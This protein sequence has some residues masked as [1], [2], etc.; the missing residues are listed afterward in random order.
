MSVNADYLSFILTDPR[1]PSDPHTV[2]YVKNESFSQSLLTSGG[3]SVLPRAIDGVRAVGAATRASP[4]PGVDYQYDFYYVRNRHSLAFDEMGGAPIDLDPFIDYGSIMYGEKLEG[5]KPPDL[6]RS[7]FGGVPYTFGGWYVEAGGFTRLDFNALPSARMPNDDLLLFA[8][9]DAPSYTARFFDAVGGAGLGIDQSVAREGKAE[10]PAGYVRGVTY[11]AGKG[12]FNGWLYYSP[13]GVLTQYNFDLPVTRDMALYANWRTNGFAVS[14][15]S[16]AG[17]GAVPVDNLRYGLFTTARALGGEGLIPPAGHV[18]Y[19]WRIEG[20]LTGTSYL[21]GSLFTIVNDMTL[22][23]QYYPQR[24]TPPADGYDPGPDLPPAAPTPAP[25]PTEESP[26]IE[27]DPQAPEE[28][29]I[30]DVETPLAEDPEERGEGNGTPTPPS[31][32][33][34]QN[35]ERPDREEPPP[36]RDE[37]Q[38]VRDEPQP[39]EEPQDEV[40]DDA[41]D[42]EEDDVSYDVTRSSVEFVGEEKSREEINRET[43]TMLKDAGVPILILGNMEIPLFGP[44]WASTWALVNLILSMAGAILAIVITVRALLYR[45]KHGREDDEETELIEGGLQLDEIS[46]TNGKERKKSRMGWFLISV[47]LAMASVLLFLLTQDIRNLMVLTDVWTIA[48]A[49]I[50]S[51]EIVAVSLIKKKK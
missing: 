38:P 31:D 26:P 37:P 45:K 8:K 12:I 10:A 43:L 20:D 40:P 9:W 23:A 46:R 13:L 16:G 2:G 29:Y 27:D 5:Y 34:P 50:L 1:Y 33:S 30:P 17:G 35:P 24:S 47:M 19:D 21:P 28:E 22:V 39:E 36:V 7:P 6:A 18:F 11:V 4:E 15:L 32:D 25:P 51:A 14:Y 49:V 41:I 42:A 44:S 48:N 3:G